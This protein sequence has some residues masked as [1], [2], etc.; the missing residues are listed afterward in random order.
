MGKGFFHIP[1]PADP[2]GQGSVHR[3]V[4]FLPGLLEGGFPIQVE[5]LLQAGP[6]GEGPFLPQ[7][8]LELLQGQADLREGG[9]EP[10]ALPGEG[11]QEG[12][13]EGQDPGLL[14]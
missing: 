14:G 8:L 3:P 1:A 9:S 6:V 7:A 4:G 13:G 11:R 5:K 12:G 10:Q 2:A